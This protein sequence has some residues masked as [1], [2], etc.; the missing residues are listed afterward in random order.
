MS[1]VL[2]GRSAEFL[3]WLKYVVLVA[4]VGAAFLVCCARCSQA[5]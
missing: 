2:L 5:D 3:P 4:G 1:F